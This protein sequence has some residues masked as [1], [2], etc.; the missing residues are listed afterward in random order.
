MRRVVK[1]SGQYWNRPDTIETIWTLLKPYGHYWNRPDII[2]TVRILLKLSGHYW[3][4]PGSIE[5]VWTLL[6][7]SGQ[8]QNRPASGQ[9]WNSPDTIESVWTMWK[10]SGQ[11]WNS[12]ETNI[13]NHLETSALKRDLAKLLNVCFHLLLKCDLIPI[14]LFLWRR[15]GTKEMLVT[16]FD[17]DGQFEND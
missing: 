11:C 14:L 13:F 2:E 16:L 6:N 15:K 1:P 9:Y 3:N 17:N 5:T 7:A 12:P 8:Y 10:L 4:P